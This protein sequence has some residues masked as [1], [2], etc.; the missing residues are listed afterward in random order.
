MVAARDNTK[1]CATVVKHSATPW[2]ETKQSI[3][4]KHTII[5]NTTIS[6]RFINE[7]ELYYISDI[8]DS[9]IIIE[10]IQSTFNVMVTI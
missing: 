2:N 9:S 6:V 1:F 5:I 3:C 7:D 10:Y 4:V 8:L